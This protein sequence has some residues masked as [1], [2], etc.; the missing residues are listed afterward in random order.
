MNIH[1]TSNIVEQRVRL[2]SKPP[3]PS[4]SLKVVQNSDTAKSR[5]IRKTLAHGRAGSQP[6]LDHDGNGS[7][8]KPVFS[9]VRGVWSYKNCRGA[10]FSITFE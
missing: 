2:T 4:Y 10:D 5:R 9:R 7:D 8:R 3:R 6:L 1:Y